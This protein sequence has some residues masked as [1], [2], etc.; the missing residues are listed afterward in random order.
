MGLYAVPA[1]GN[2]KELNNTIKSALRGDPKTKKIPVPINPK[3]CSYKSLREWEEYENAKQIIVEELSL[4]QSKL[5]MAMTAP[6]SNTDINNK[7]PAP[8]HLSDLQLQHPLKGRG[9]LSSKFKDKSNRKHAHNGL[10]FS[11]PLGTPVYPI[12]YGR[13]VAIRTVGEFI[14]KSNMVKRRARSHPGFIN[15]DPRLIDYKHPN[16]Q[17]NTWRCGLKQYRLSLIHI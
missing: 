10:D 7:D 6:R 8:D 11:A 2:N 1:D 9:R 4:R 3:A 13:V 17:K 14:E 15:G 12:T 16:I 5:S